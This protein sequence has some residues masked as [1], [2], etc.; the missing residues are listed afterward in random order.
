MTVGNDVSRPGSATTRDLPL[1]PWEGTAQKT[2]SWIVDAV[3]VPGDSPPIDWGAVERL[4]SKGECN[5]LPPPL[6]FPVETE[7][8]MRLN[9]H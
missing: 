1:K 4:M 2:T 8:P 5:K 6:G 7:I 3:A 9:M